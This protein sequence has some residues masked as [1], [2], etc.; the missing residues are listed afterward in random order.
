MASAYVC[1]LEYTEQYADIIRVGQVSLN[2]LQLVTC[3]GTTYMT[4]GPIVL[5]MNQ[6]A[7][8]EKVVLSILW[9]NY[10]ILVLILMINP[11]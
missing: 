7:Y 6:Y 9:G 4:Q 10:L 1:M 2:A 11:Q 5:V 3:A 8:M